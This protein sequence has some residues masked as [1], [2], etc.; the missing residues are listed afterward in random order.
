MPTEDATLPEGAF[1]GR[2]AFQSQLHAALDAAARE[3]WRELV[4]SD[5]TFADWPL[6]ERTSIERLN[7]W[8]SSGRTLLLLAGSFS[9]FERDHMRF[10]EWRRTWSHIVDCRA[11][12]ARSGARRGRCIGSTSNAAAASAVAI[13]SVAGR[14]GSR[15]MSAFDAAGL[16]FRRRRSGFERVQPTPIPCQDG[17]FV[18]CK[19]TPRSRFDAPKRF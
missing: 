7:A 5:P 11:C 16:H 15:S 19:P 9:V 18:R 17:A 8:A 3:G 2:A 12:R 1:D 10:V 4:F 14:C 6:G 13:R